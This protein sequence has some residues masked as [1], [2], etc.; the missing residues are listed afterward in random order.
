MADEKTMEAS[1]KPMSPSA[2]AAEIAYRKRKGL[3]PL[4]DGDIAALTAGVPM[5]WEAGGTPAAA[6]TAQPAAPPTAPPA[7]ASQPAAAASVPQPAAAP[8]AANVAMSGILG[9]LPA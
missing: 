5:P 1:G 9:G 4:T 6:A 8:A 7:S 2:I 3:P